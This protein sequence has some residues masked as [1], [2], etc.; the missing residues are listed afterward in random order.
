M[1]RFIAT[2]LLTLGISSGA[3]MAA[4]WNHGGAG[5][6]RPVAAEHRGF[7]RG[8]AFQRGEMVGRERGFNRGFNRG[9]R[10]GFERGEARGA[11]FHERAWRR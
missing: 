10:R 4:P 3:A 2:T 7:E 6:G 5:Y 9:E 8:R 11:R 1:R